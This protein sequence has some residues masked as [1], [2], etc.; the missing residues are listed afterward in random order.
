VKALLGRYAFECFLK[1]DFYES[2]ILSEINHGRGGP[3][4]RL[5]AA[6]DKVNIMM[7]GAAVGKNLTGCLPFPS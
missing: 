2:A 4:Q 3:V 5:V 1:R 7:G 6:S